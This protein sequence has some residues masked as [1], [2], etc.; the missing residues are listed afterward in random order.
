[1]I[2]FSTSVADT[3]LFISSH[4]SVTIYMLVYYVDDT[5]IASS[6]VAATDHLLCHLAATFLVKDLGQLQYFMGIKVA[7]IFFRENAKDL[8]V[9]FH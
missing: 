3:S 4:G 6:S 2:G 1:V 8:C 5:V 7:H 9:S